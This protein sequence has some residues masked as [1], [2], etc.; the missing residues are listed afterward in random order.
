MSVCGSGILGGAVVAVACIKVDFRATAAATG[1][2][3]SSL[4][5]VSGANFVVFVVQNV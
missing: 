5:I 1:A 3:T 4:V 2:T